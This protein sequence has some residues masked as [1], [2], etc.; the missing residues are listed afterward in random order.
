MGTCLPE[1]KE[2][3]KEAQK[4]NKARSCEAG[5][6]DCMGGIKT[7]KACPVNSG[8]KINPLVDAARLTIGIAAL[9]YMVSNGQEAGVGY[10]GWGL[11]RI[12][13]WWRAWLV[14]RNGCVA[15]E[16]DRRLAGGSGAPLAW[17][18]I[19]STVFCMVAMSSGVVESERYAVL[20]SLVLFA[21]LGWSD[22]KRDASKWTGKDAA[23]K[24]R[25]NAWREARRAQALHEA[26]LIEEQ[27]KE[28]VKKTGPKRL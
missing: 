18:M 10:K 26:A 8:E 22:V 28:G 4:R 11:K 1:P 15:R 14:A 27:V 9:R 23:R 12:R 17:W 21:A 16:A 5:R 7:V 6:G 20:A 13:I 19:I 2:R 24:A 3:R 25:N